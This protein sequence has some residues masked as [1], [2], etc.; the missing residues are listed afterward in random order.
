[1]VCL[2]G[3]RPEAA[4]ASFLDLWDVHSKKKARL[5]WNM[6]LERGA[7]LDWTLNAARQDGP[8]QLVRLSAALIGDTVL[9]IAGDDDTFSQTDEHAYE[10]LSAIVNELSVAHRQAAKNAEHMRSA[11]E[12][13]RDARRRGETLQNQLRFLAGAGRMGAG[14]AVSVEER[15]NAA[16]AY[17]LPTL[18]EFCTIDVCA[19][20]LARLALGRHINPQLQ[21]SLDDALRD[22]A[23]LHALAPGELFRVPLAMRNASDAWIYVG[24][25]SRPF[26]DDERALTN[27]F[28]NIVSVALDNALLY[29]QQRSI[30]EQLQRALLPAL[31]PRSQE[32][33]LD[34]LYLPNAEGRETVGGDWYD[35][36]VLPDGSLAVSIGDV[37]GHGIYAAAMMGK[38]RQAIRTAALNTRD[39]RLVLR[40]ASRGLALEQFLATALYGRLDRRTNRF[41]YAIAGHPPPILV[42]G[43]SSMLLPIGGVPLGMDDMEVPDPGRYE[44]QLESGDSII[45]YTDGLI[46]ATRDITRGLAQLMEA[47]QGYHRRGQYGPGTLRMFVQTVLAETDA[48]DDIAVLSLHITSEVNALSS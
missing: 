48:V 39:P 38:V 2:G 19:G 33:L 17:A 27:Q 12:G 26:T 10:E 31:L 32:V 41:V 9:V 18:G 35:A 40:R 21:P 7:A 15:I 6:V 44:V 25:T 16:L 28:A 30:S 24:R 37:T 22:K 43:G 14:D 34:A 46:E 11:M 47:A 13:E 20:G 36:F 8:P 3:V 5:F 23:A 42:R 1:M 29:E 45:L 4:T